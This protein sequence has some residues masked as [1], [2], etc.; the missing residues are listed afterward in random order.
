M[1]N[2]ANLLWSLECSP[3]RS[4]PTNVPAC[5]TPTPATSAASP[6]RPPTSAGSPPSNSD[7]QRAI[8]NLDQA[9]QHY[10]LLGDRGGY[11]EA[12]EGIAQ[13]AIS[14]GDYARA[15]SLLAAADGLREA[16]NHPIAPIDRDHYNDM[17]VTLRKNWGSVR[18]DLGSRSRAQL[19]RGQ[20]AHHR[21]PERRPD[22]GHG[23]PA[24]AGNGQAEI[25]S[26]IKELGISER[27]IEVLT[28]VAAGKTDKDIA[29]ELFIGVRTVQSHVANLLTKLEVNARSAAVARALRAGIIT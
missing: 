21:D 29:D 28:L 1:T 10:D 5:S 11:A 14:T 16:V 7:Y 20:A 24:T 22:P 23:Q 12:L 17:I 25:N 9:L 2:V 8:P 26:L 13:V 4:K 27:E 19:R 18:C 3:K 6:G 15:A